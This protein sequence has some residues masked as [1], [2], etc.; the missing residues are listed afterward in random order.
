MAAERTFLAYVR[1]AFAMFVT[2][3]TGSQLFDNPVLAATGYALAAL[4]LV[5]FAVGV[6]RFLRARRVA[7][8]MLL[9]L[10]SP[11]T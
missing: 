1:S 2:G 5:V 9:R 3:V 6:W 10:G 8:A 7:A 4:S 11:A